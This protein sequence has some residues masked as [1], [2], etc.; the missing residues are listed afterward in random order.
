MRSKLGASEL[1]LLSEGASPKPT[2]LVRSVSEV[3]RTGWWNT[4][5]GWK[6]GQTFNGLLPPESQEINLLGIDSFGPPQHVTIALARTDDLAAAAGTNADVIAR[7]QY[8]IGG[9]TVQFFGDWCNGM[10]LS[11]PCVTLRVSAVA[12]RGDPFAPYVAR[13]VTLTAGLGRGEGVALAPTRTLLVTLP[14][15]AG[16]LAP[17]PDF[18][19]TLELSGFEAAGSVFDANTVV[20]F[21]DAAGNVIAEYDGTQLAPGVRVSVPGQAAV[22]TVINTSANTRVVNLIFGLGL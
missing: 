6:V 18:A 21:S 11:I 12:V 4:Q 2:A 10:T 9:M 8:G 15:A 13:R 3:A 5:E 1:E 20:S 16:G 14:A 17:V 19:R 7:V 22:V